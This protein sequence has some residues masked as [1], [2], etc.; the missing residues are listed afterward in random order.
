MLSISLDSNRGRLTAAINP[1]STATVL[2]ALSESA[3][4]RWSK[5][6]KA[7]E[8]LPH[9]FIMLALDD[10]VWVQSARSHQDPDRVR[11]A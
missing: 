3:A 6:A 10:Q 8:T 2:A 11:P 7:G 4:E 9:V 5:E 1:A